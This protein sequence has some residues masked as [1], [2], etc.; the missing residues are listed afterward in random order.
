VIQLLLWLFII[1]TAVIV[2]RLVAWVFWTRSMPWSCPSCFFGGD[3]DLA[4]Q[5]REW[6][7]E[8]WGGLVQCRQCGARFKE[9]PNGMLVEDRDA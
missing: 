1:G 3:T 4:D 8:L 9:H 7:V 6:Y 5:P 2:V